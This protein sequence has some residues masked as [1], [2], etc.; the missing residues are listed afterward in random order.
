MLD[1]HKVLSDV[2]CWAREIGKVQR[3]KLGQKHTLHTKSSAFDLVTEVDQLS[4]QYLIAC[5]KEKYPGHEIFAEESG[6]TVGQS[7]YMWVVDPLDGTVNYNQGIPVFAVSIALRYRSETVLGVI[8][9]PVLDELFEVIKGQKPR[10]NG[11]EIRVS[12]KN[13]LEESVLGSGFPYDRAVH[14][15]NNAKYFSHFVPLVRGLR[16]MGAAA[17]DLASVAAGRLDGYWELNLSPWDVEAGALLVREAGGRVI[18]LT[19]KR[20]VSVVAGNKAICDQIFAEIK[21]VDGEEPD[22]KNT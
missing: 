12:R 18:Y 20:G 7:E 3:E 10:L 5:I 16:R 13:R 14:S 19:E 9:Q 2:C 6:R 11:L 15:D 1:L 17:Y 4:E 21:R 8:Y 22:E